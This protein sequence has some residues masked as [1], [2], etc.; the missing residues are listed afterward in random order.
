[1]L[2]EPQFYQKKE[3]TILRVMQSE[4]NLKDVQEIHNAKEK[5]QPRVA[6]LATILVLTLHYYF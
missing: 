2:K 4:G 6:L 5:K 3:A 1:P